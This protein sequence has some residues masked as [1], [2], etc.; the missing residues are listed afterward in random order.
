MAGSNS[1][2]EGLGFTLVPPG[3]TLIADLMPT[4]SSAASIFLPFFTLGNYS[5]ALG[6]I[7]CVDFGNCVLLAYCL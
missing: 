5:S 4:L 2:R 3:N 7:F 1:A 6:F